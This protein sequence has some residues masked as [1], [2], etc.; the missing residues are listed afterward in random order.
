M[1]CVDEDAIVVLE[2]FAKKTQATPKQAI[3][4]CQNRLRVYR[5]RTGRM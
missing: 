3:E 4:L 1:Y 5:E 2:T